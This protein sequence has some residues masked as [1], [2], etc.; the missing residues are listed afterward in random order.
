[1]LSVSD[2]L[3]VQSY[4]HDTSRQLT[5]VGPPF[6][7]RSMYMGYPDSMW[8]T[9]KPTGFA[10][11]PQELIDLI[12]DNLAHDSVALRSC[13]F[14]CRSWLK[15]CRHHLFGLL[16]VRDTQVQ[17]SLRSRPVL[18]ERFQAF[19]TFITSVASPGFCAKVHTL[20][21][22]GNEER[23]E[24]QAPESFISAHMLAAILGQ[25]PRVRI[26]ELNRVN[27]M[28]LP[29][30]SHSPI[31]LPLGKVKLDV[32]SIGRI[33]LEEHAPDGLFSILGLFSTLGMLR[34]SYLETPRNTPSPADLTRLLERLQVH[35]LAPT[36]PQT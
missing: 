1:M 26:L 10:R 12:V 25:L 32:L 7:S 20:C 31:V 34:I 35:R 18:Q 13:S 19:L 23:H 24:R 2:T 17:T 30:E 11:L 6:S 4:A 36:P 5:T 15:Q 9:A 14:V 22:L 33:G 28:P 16:R 3:Y 21:L 29:T 8:S 27:F